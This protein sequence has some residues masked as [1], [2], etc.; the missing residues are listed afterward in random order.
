VHQA[1]Y[2]KD[3]LKKF[4]MDDLKPLSTPMSMT[5]ALDVDEDGEPMDL[6]EYRS[7][8]GSLLYWTVM[9]PDI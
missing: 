1:K 2:T 7:I 6:K 5:T 9:R 8:I 4:K 3:I